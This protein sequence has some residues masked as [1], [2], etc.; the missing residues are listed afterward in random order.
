MKILL[1]Q[2]P[3]ILSINLCFYLNSKKHLCFFN[4]PTGRSP[5]CWIYFFPSPPGE[6]SPVRFSPHKIKKIYLENLSPLLQK[7][8]YV[9]LCH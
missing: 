6:R 9:N 7:T 4:Y 2:S 3:L 1:R 8:C 5:H